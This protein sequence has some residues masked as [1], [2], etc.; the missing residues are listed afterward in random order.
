M[1]WKNWINTC[2]APCQ[3]P[4]IGCDGIRK[5]FSLSEIFSSD[6]LYPRAADEDC[7]VHKKG[8][9]SR[10]NPPTNIIFLFLFGKKKGERKTKES[11]RISQVSIL[12]EIREVGLVFHVGGMEKN[13]FSDN[14]YIKASAVR[15]DVKAI[16]YSPAPSCHCH[17]RDRRED[18]LIKMALSFLYFFLDWKGN[19]LTRETFQMCQLESTRKVN[20]SIL[21]LLGFRDRKRQ[22]IYRS[23]VGCV[24][25]RNKCCDS[26]CV[27]LF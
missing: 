1:T 14:D 20:P 9:R 11:Y 25:S 27:N 18:P 4:N 13:I 12:L 3:C 7:A 19:Q 17:H 16:S 5:S 2:K 24:E 22:S 15:N 23:N 26:V 8:Y 21:T 6:R 10:E